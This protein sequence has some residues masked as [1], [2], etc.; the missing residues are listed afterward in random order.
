MTPQD[1]IKKA[2]KHNVAVYCR[3]SAV[4]ATRAGGELDHTFE[5]GDRW[6]KIGVYTKDCPPEWIAEDL[7]YCNV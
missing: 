6:K 3:G 4:K 1:I 7:E 2:E 5:T